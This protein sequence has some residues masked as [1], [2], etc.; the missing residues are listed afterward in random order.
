M[1]YAFQKHVLIVCIH[2]G[3]AHP[4]FVDFIFIIISLLCESVYCHQPPK[5]GR[6]KGHLMSYGFGVDVNTDFAV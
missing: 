5:R 6:L 4:Y 2:L 3:G 1:H